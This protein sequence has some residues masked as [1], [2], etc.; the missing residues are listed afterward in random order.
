MPLS[1]TQAKYILVISQAKYN[2][3]ELKKSV[4]NVEKHCVLLE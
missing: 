3:S 4:K 2:Y 1:Y